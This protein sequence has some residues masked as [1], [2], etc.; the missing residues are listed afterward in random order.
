MAVGYKSHVA[1]IWSVRSSSV[2]N[3]VQKIIQNRGMN[4]EDMEV[5]KRA[6]NAHFIFFMSLWY[7][8][9]DDF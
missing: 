8:Q 9:A 3:V 2:Q 7:K 1:C 6:Q 4:D 5:L